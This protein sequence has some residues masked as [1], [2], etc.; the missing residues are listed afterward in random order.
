MFEK[1]CLICGRSYVSDI[2]TSR[3][4]NA[5]HEILARELATV[6]VACAHCGKPVLCGQSVAHRKHYCDGLCKAAHKGLPPLIRKCIVCGKDFAVEKH[7][8]RQKCCSHKCASK[9]LRKVKKPQEGGLEVPPP[10]R[11][12]TPSTIETW[13]VCVGY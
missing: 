10:P 13:D 5:H 3:G 7:S 1:V 6:Q 8:S 9:S 12:L 11:I 2:R 4:C